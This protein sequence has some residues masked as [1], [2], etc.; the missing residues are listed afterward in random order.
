MWA[1]R[2]LNPGPNGNGRHSRFF[3]DILISRVFEENIFTWG[4]LSLT[5]SGDSRATYLDAIYTADKGDLSP[6][7]KFARS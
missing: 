5:Q 3:A 6:L 7:L 4:R 1:L 2:D